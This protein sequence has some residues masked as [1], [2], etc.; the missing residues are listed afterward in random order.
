[1]RDPDIIIINGQQYDALT[2]KPLGGGVSDITAGPKAKP[3]INYRDPEIY[4][5]QFVNN[6]V[7]PASHSIPRQSSDA[8]TI[9][10][11]VRHPA[12]QKAAD[13]KRQPAKSKTLMRKPLTKPDFA[14]KTSIAPIKKNNYV[15]R[16]TP[17][18]INRGIVPN[19][20]R[21]SLVAR[22]QILKTKASEVA[23]NLSVE[24]AIN[25]T[26][27]HDRQIQKIQAA[28]EDQLYRAATMEIQDTKPVK[29]KK[30]R[31]KRQKRSHL[32]RNLYIS[33]GVLLVLVIIGAG[34]LYFK[35]S[36]ELD[37]ANMKTGISGSYPSYLPLG[38]KLVKMEYQKTPGVGSINP[39]YAPANNQLN[40]YLYIAESSTNLDNAGLLASEVNPVAQS[41]Y[42]T[43]FVKG[44]SVY[45]FHDQYVWVNAGMQYIITDQTGL[46]Q[47]TVTKII[48]S[49]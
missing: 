47:D 12:H 45:H 18:V 1:M 9:N 8:L 3:G 49:I 23:A 29:T 15:R 10:D 35:S 22:G 26:S 39:K 21:D 11:V 7:A 4:N 34:G 33:L 36:L 30:T 25:S 14:P 2:G 32:M 24:P 46:S 19:S 42:Q 44:N 28:D 48:N 37:Y 38:Y 5:K 41:N 27:V 6:D 40:Q 17:L 20:L 43:I 31:V 16:D 13:I